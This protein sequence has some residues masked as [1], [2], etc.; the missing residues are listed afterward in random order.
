MELPK[1]ITKQ[2]FRFSTLYQ[3]N[4]VENLKKTYDNFSPIAFFFLF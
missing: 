4:K 3:S 1:P 2:M